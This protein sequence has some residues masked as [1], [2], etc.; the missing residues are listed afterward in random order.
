VSVRRRRSGVGRTGT[1]AAAL[2]LLCGC[3]GGSA[4]G[5]DGAG[6]SAAPSSSAASEADGNPVL[7]ED[8]PDPDVLEVD[9]TYYAYATNGNAHN[10]QV[11]TSTDLVSWEVSDADALPELPTWV[12]PGKTWAPEVSRL[13]PGRFVMYTTTTNFEPTLQCVAVATATTPEGPFEVV[14]D[15]M[16]VCPE[17]EGGAI[18]AATFTDDDGTR[19][20]LWKNDGNCCGFDTWLSIAPLSDDGLTLAGP[21]TRLVKQDQE[22][23]GD[24]V[25]APTLVKRDGRY[26]L[27]YSANDYGGDQYAIGYATADAVTGPYTKAGEPLFTTEASDGRYIGPGG[28]DVVPVTDGTERVV[29]HSWYGGNT[30]R[31]MNVLDLTWENGRPLVGQ[32]ASPPR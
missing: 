30:Y 2:V 31:G 4:G 21:S 7:D 20:L 32:E 27:M 10:V 5:A 18:D 26:V 11:A 9:G 1:A 19:Y 15:R 14:G 8:F 29:F 22:W 17:D 16:L 6:S 25:E 13:G 28:Q 3:G 24:L 12:I 23:E